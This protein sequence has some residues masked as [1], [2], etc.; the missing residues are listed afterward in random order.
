MDN[1]NSDGLIAVKNVIR[2]IAKNEIRNSS[3]PTYIAAV[4]QNI[5]DNGTINVFIPPNQ[6]NTVTNLLNKT[7]ERLETGDSVEIAT[8]NGSL[9]NCW[10]AIKHGTTYP[11]LTITDLQE[12][13]KDLKQSTLELKRRL[14]KDI[15]LE[16]YPVGS[17]YISMNSTAPDI[18]FGGS[19]I[20]IGVGRTLVSAGGGREGGSS[21]VIDSN[22]YT[23]R[24]TYSAGTEDWFPV[25]ETGG[26]Q[27]HTLTVAQIPSHNHN[28]TYQNY[29]GKSASSG[30][31]ITY[32]N[33]A[34]TAKNKASANKGDGKA[35][36]IMQP[37]LAVYMWQRTA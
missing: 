5:N 30:S 1:S 8:K 15:F 6:S 14:D 9:T 26:E 18:L 23:G 24:G 2:E 11:S 20:R 17:I 33:I 36:N 25:G 16:I 28:V 7:G 35:H 29:S 37:Y 13:V 12:E 19:W 27:D 21:P 34:G 22:N 32:T 10:I 4:V 3:F 31:N